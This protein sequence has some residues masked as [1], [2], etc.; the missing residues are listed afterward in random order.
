MTLDIIGIHGIS[1]TLGRANRSFV[2][3][4]PQGIP[5]VPTTHTSTCGAG[6]VRVYRRPP[7]GS[8]RGRE[9]S[10]Q[11]RPRCRAESRRDEFAVTSVGGHKSRYRS[12]CREEVEKKGREEE[13][14]RSRR[15]RKGRA[16]RGGRR[17]MEKKDIGARMRFIHR[18][19]RNC[20]CDIS[21]CT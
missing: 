9:S 7:T 4:T 11:L 21:A 1:E 20:S 2:N 19:S 18:V 6:H 14:K 3:A 12:G 16:K 15:K 5:S 13:E 8:N 10:P 17:E